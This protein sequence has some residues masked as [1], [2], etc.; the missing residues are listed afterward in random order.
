M[1]HSTAQEFGKLL[2]PQGRIINKAAAKADGEPTWTQTAWLVKINPDGTPV[3]TAVVTYVNTANSD[4]PG[5]A[6]PAGFAAM[7]VA[8]T[9]EYEFRYVHRDLCGGPFTMT[10]QDPSTGATRAT[11]I[12]RT[13]ICK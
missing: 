11:R 4:C 1:I 3:P 5:Y 8:P 7:H 2:Y 13:S 10:T 12:R 6:A 9:G